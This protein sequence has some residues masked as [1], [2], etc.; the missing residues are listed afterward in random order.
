[1]KALIVEDDFTGRLLLQTFLSRYGECHVAVNGKEAVEAFRAASQAGQ[2][3]DLICMDIMM[4]EMDG[5]AALRKIRGCEEAQGIPSDRGV[6]IIMTT[7]LD[8][9]KSVFRSF[10][11]LCD[12]YLTKPIDTAKLL[13]YLQS[14]KLAA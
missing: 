11:E 9:M 7:A 13:G 5:Q 6:K 2:A 14:F 10:H 4:P 12:A 1:M 3:Y 8:D